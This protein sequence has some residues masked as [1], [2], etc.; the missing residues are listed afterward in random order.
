MEFETPQPYVIFK[1]YIA[2]MVNLQI[3]KEVMQNTKLTAGSVK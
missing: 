1:K 3:I 2:V